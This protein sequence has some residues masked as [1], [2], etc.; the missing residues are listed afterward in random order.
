MA[1]VRGHRP[2]RPGY[3]R[4]TLEAP[5]ITG[6]AQAG[7]FVMIR[8]APTLEP[9][10]RRP[11]SIFA[12]RPENG[13]LEILYRVVGRGTQLLSEVREGSPVDIVGPLGHGYTLLPEARTIAVVGRGVGVA[14]VFSVAQA[15]RREGRRVFAF[16]SA[17]TRDLLLA[18]EDLKRLGCQVEISTDD[19]DAGYQGLVTD[20]LAS[21]AKSEG[22]GQVF[23]CGS[24]RL[25]RAAAEI[26]R[27]AGIRAQVS[28]EQQMA[29]GVA[30]CMG[31]ARLV[32]T[33][34]NKVYKKVCKDGPVFWIEEVLD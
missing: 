26:A 12:T 5:Q 23:V 17:R 14:S 34:G 22:I 31:C 13:E 27:E 10:L 2:E 6:E 8:C 7:Q 21:K 20:L 24:R 28:L 15:A 18:V 30:A 32:G 11:F 16:V 25:I 9:L 4:L 19:G 29:C 33:P 3:Y 1:A